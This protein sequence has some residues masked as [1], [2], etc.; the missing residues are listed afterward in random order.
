MHSHAQL[1][2]QCWSGLPVSLLPWDFVLALCGV[3]PMIRPR[4]DPASTA[5]GLQLHTG[6]QCCTAPLSLWGN[7]GAACL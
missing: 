7:A 2:G 4:G 1:A 6:V 5:D 3:L